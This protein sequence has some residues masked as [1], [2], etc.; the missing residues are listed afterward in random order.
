M[1]AD[2]RT[3]LSLAPWFSIFP[4]LA[5]VVTVLALNMFGDALRDQLDPHSTRGSMG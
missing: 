5:I 4:G 3:Y 1:L 2:S